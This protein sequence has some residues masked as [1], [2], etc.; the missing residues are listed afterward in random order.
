MSGEDRSGML[1]A[2]LVPA[3]VTGIPDIRVWVEL[4]VPSPA[5]VAERPKTKPAAVVIHCAALPRTAIY[6]APP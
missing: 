5:V 6:C 3:S 2:S 1:K 4:P